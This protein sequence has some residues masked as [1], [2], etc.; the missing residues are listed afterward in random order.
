MKETNEESSASLIAKQTHNDWFN[1]SGTNSKEEKMIRQEFS[2][3]EMVCQQCGVLSY[4]D[5]SNARVGWILDAPQVVAVCNGCR[6]KHTLILEPPF[7][8]AAS[9][10]QAHEAELDSVDFYRGLFNECQSVQEEFSF[11]KETENQSQ[12]CAKYDPDDYL[13]S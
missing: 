7:G 8:E 10:I 6:A 3:L 1:V 11:V 13:K 12:K 5:I 4:L 9:D 2:R